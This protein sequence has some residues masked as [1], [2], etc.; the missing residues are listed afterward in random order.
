MKHQYNIY[1]FVLKKAIFT[2]RR[3]FRS[4]KNIADFSITV[5]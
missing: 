1:D 2:R 3:G 5:H 4:E